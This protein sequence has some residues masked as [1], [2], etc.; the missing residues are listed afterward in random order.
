MQS[1]RTICAQGEN[2]AVRERREPGRSESPTFVFK[3]NNTK[4]V[5]FSYKRFLETNSVNHSDLQARLYG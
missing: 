1:P 5:H 4:L 2:D 3:V